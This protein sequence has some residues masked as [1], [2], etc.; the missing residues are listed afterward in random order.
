MIE[1]QIPIKVSR[2]LKERTDISGANIYKSLH[3]L[4]CPGRPG[5]S[6]RVLKVDTF[7]SEQSFLRDGVPRL[8]VGEQ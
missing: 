8:R 2:D 1:I 3:L 4:S 7:T 5:V 6:Y